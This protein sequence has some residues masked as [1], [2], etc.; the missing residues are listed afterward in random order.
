MTM[1]ACLMLI[2]T[3]CAKSGTNSLK[4][5]VYLPP[6]PAD[7]VTCFDKTTPPPQGALTRGQVMRLIAQ[8]RGNERNLQACGKRLQAFY[9]QFLKPENNNN[10]NNKGEY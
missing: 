5:G 1:F 4:T 8:M 2:P 9:N 10:K 3:G 6:L 7:L